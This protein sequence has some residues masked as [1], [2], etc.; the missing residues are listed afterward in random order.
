MPDEATNTAPSTEAS[1]D[2]PVADT[3]TEAPITDGQGTTETPDDAEQ[4]YLRHSDY[5]RKTQELAEQ[6]RAFEAEQES[7]LHQQDLLQRMIAEGDEDAAQELLES[8]G[9]DFSDEAG[10]DYHSDP[11]TAQLRS[12]LNELTEWK[13]QQEAEAQAR[14]GAAYVESEFNRLGLGSWDSE[15]PLHDAVFTHAL[16]A[17]EDGN[18]DVQAGFDKVQALREHFINEYRES[19][20]APSTDAFGSPAE[21]AN[22]NAS[23]SD[24]VAAAMERNGLTA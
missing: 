6:R 10:E 20:S 22:T 18:P 5:T 14:E 9:Y 16:I 21:P 8:I 7:F 1:F 12:Q 15:N 13:A 4:G 24:R 3:P 19:K 2:A 11:E 23:L 17:G